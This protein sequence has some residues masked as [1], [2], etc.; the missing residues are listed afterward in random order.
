MRIGIL[1]GSIGWHVQELTRALA[2]RGHTWMVLPITRL[3]G[4]I[5]RE[6]RFLARDTR[7]DTLD[8]ILVRTIPRGSLEQIIFRMDTLHLLE[9]RGV[10]VINSAH[11]I[12]QT[13]D[14]YYTSGLLAQ[15]GVPTPR[16]ITCEHAEDAMD[17]FDRLGRDV[18]I[19]PLFGSMGAGMVRVSDPDIAY[20]VFKALD[21]ERAVYYVQEFI[22]HAGRDIRAFVI[23]HRVVAAMERRADDWRT[24]ATRGARVRSI[25]LTPELEALCVRVAR[26]VGAEYAG[27]DLLPGQ[28]GRVYVLEINSIPGWQALQRTTSV[29]IAGMIVRYIETRKISSVSERRTP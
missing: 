11:T 27:V 26:I 28:D 16:T 2:A 18:V 15:A 10:A 3:I 23:G 8:A 25:Q 5:D 6:M 12:E 4:C 21:L 1:T 20:R 24:N 7:L 17:A 9:R 14:K 19:K 13:V 22:P 29:D